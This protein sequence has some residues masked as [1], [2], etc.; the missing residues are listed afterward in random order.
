[1]CTF[2]TSAGP[3]HPQPIHWDFPL[4][5]H[6][7]EDQPV[8]HQQAYHSQLKTLTGNMMPRLIDLL[9]SYSQKEDKVVYCPGFFDL[10]RILYVV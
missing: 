8:L 3:V 5:L 10:Y 7:L 1:M 9:L 2:C 4:P 6:W